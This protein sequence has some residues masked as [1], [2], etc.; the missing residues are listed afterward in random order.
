LLVRTRY[1]YGSLRLR[2]RERG[3]DVW[4]FR[5]YETDSQGKRKRQSVIL[6]DRNLLP[7]ETHARKATQA[8]LL[9]LNEESPRAEVEA[10]SFGALLDRYI[11]QEL[12][13][14]YSTRKSHLSNIRVHIRP[15]WGEYPVDKLKPMAMEQWLRDLP[16]APKSKTHVRGIM[17]LVFKCA[18]RWGIVELGKNPVSLVRVKDGSKRLK[19]P[20]VLDVGQFFELLKH[21]GEPYRTM[22]LVAQCLGLRVSEILA[23]QWGDFNFE[24]RS[25]LVQRS[26]VGGRV[27]D[28]K[29]EYSRD[30]VPLDARLAEVLL[31]W[32]SVSIF[33]R[34]EDWLFANP[35]TGRPYHQESLQKS[36]IKRA[37]KLAGLGE[38]IG[39][40]TF[41]HSYRS[42]LD[43]TGAPMKVQ[44][45]LMRHASIQTTMNVYGRA[46][47]E[48]KRRANSQVVG[49]VFGPNSQDLPA[50][51]VTATVQ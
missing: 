2:K 5:Y 16:L 17:H 31:H 30:D 50:D 38:E 48:T 32:R 42:W 33:P 35:V 49:L 3:P 14:R 7:T 34:D 25:V 37:A 26:V 12:S 46:M 8:L 15:R 22:V 41:R 6:G 29:T 24:N 9:R 21:L 10:A 13:E 28:V 36:Q 4:E 20:R 11:E 51:A 43:E 44:Q 40:H 45:E 18:E 19:R 47:T 27:D 23:L 1:Q 39:W